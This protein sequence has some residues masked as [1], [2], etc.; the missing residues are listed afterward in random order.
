MV[1]QDLAC[2]RREDVP[3]ELKLMAKTRNCQYSSDQGLPRVFPYIPSD[4]RYA[5]IPR[6]RALNVP[7]PRFPRWFVVNDNEN[8]LEWLG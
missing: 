2:G 6:S 5:Y 7:V 4:G 3:S 1:E 8:P